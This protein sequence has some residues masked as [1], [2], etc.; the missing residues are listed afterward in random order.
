M[1]DDRAHQYRDRAEE[2][3]TCAEAMRD[4]GA[5]AG[6]LHIAECYEAMAAREISRRARQHSATD[7]PSPLEEP[8]SATA[9]WRHS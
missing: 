4:A 5:Q 3:R 8:F 6:L 2:C 7:A 1:A 9:H